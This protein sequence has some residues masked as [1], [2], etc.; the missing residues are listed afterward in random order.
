MVL[1]GPTKLATLYAAPGAAGELDRAELQAL[2]HGE[3]HPLWNGTQMISGTRIFR[4]S[5]SAGKA[6]MDKG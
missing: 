6:I 5:L 1:A 4:V 3:P 2:E